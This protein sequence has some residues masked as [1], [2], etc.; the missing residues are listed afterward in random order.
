MK[1]I[2]FYVVI[3]TLAFLTASCVEN[4]E[5]YKAAIASRD[6]LAFEKQASDSNYIRTLTILND[7]E[8]GFSEITQNENQMKIN[9]KGVEGTTNKKELI[10]AQ[11]NAIKESMEQNKAK[12]AELQKLAAKKGKA[13][14][15]LASTIKRLQTEL[16]EKTV[17]IQS[18]QAELEQKNIKITELTTTVNDQSKNIAEQQTAMEQQKS[19]IKGQDTDLNTVWYCVATAKKLKEEKIVSTAGLFQSKKVLDNEFDKDA[20]TQVDLRNVSSIPT[21]SKRVKILSLHPKNSYNLVTGTDKNITI[22]ITN[23]SKFWS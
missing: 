23:P 13:N 14:S 8:T 21:N 7:I 1:T 3:A 5:K 10:A 9:L 17:Q 11:M 22:E 20:F 6:S 16:E 18:L 2:K 15:M 19:T 4:S 12:I